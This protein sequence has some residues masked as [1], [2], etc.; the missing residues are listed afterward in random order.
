M[1]KNIHDPGPIVCPLIAKA[2]IPSLLMAKVNTPCPLMACYSKSTLA[3]DDL[4][5]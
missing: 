3:F 5:Q 1:C 4:S 2:N